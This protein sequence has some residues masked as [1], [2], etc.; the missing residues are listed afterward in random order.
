VAVVLRERVGGPL[1]P[2]RVRGSV[3]ERLLR[4]QPSADAAPPP[5]THIVDVV[6]PGNQALAAGTTLDTEVKGPWRVLSLIVDFAQDMTGEVYIDGV[7]RFKTTDG[8]G[9]EGQF[10]LGNGV[11]FMDVEKVRVVATNPADLPRDVRAWMVV[12]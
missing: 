4:A 6:A 7:L 12:L 8:A 10:T 2:D 5:R 9:L 1:T 11:T 3:W